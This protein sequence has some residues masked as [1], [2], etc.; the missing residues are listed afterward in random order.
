VRLGHKLGLTLT[1]LTFLVLGLAFFAS[2]LG[3]QAV[4]TA[5]KNSR[6][7][8]VEVAAYE[9]GLAI[10]EQL[11]DIQLVA[12]E[13]DLVH[14]L[15]GLN[16]AESHKEESH[17]AATRDI[18]ATQLQ[19]VADSMRAS[20]LAAGEPTLMLG[21]YSIDGDLIAYSGTGAHREKLR[22][23]RPPGR[24]QVGLGVR[25]IT[26]Q[27]RRSRVANYRAAERHGWQNSSDAS[28]RNRFKLR[29]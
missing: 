8:R 14:S 13:P 28:R 22:R 21:I 12:A 11:A 4:R 6:C 23:T 18:V 5:V 9:I 17:S 10:E 2:F 7:E 29:L 20:R 19:T 26:I 15:S 1:T 25:T 27:G 16:K 3:E 24:A